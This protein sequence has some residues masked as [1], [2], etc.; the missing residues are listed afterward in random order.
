MAFS[1]ILLAFLSLPFFATIKHLGEAISP[2]SLMMQTLQWTATE[3]LALA[4]CFGMCPT[5]VM[6]TCPPPRELA[7]ATSQYRP[8]P[9]LVSQTLRTVVLPTR[10]ALISAME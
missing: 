4:G 7:R 9:H 5:L 1:I 2:I 10:L 3:R 6:Q 8:T